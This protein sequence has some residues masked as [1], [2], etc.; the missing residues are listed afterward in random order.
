MSDGTPTPSPPV[1]AGIGARATPQPVLNEITELAQWLAGDGWHLHSGG[2]AGADSTFA[3]ATPSDART[4]FLPWPG[5]RNLSG[6]DCH[7]AT[8]DQAHHTM[9]IAAALHPRWD[10]CSESTKQFHARNVSI[11]LGPNADSPVNAVVCWTEGGRTI[12]GTGMAIRIANAYNIPLINLGQMALDTA[13]QVLDKVREEH[14]T[15]EQ[16]ANQSASELLS[17]SRF[18]PKG[19]R[20]TIAPGIP[21]T[22]G[23]RRELTASDHQFSLD[24]LRTESSYRIHPLAIQHPRA[25]PPQYIEG[26]HSPHDGH[27]FVITGSETSPDRD[28]V[29]H[30]LDHRFPP[31]EPDSYLSELVFVHTGETPAER[32]AGE[33]AL[34]RN[35]P[36]II[37]SPHPAGEN[38]A[39][40]S[41][42]LHT[43]L[44][45]VGL[46][47]ICDFSP[48]EEHSDVTMIARAHRRIV[49]QPGNSLTHQLFPERSL[50][51]SDRSPQ[52]SDEY[53]EQDSDLSQQ[54]AH[55]ARTAYDPD[56]D[57]NAWRDLDEER[58]LE[59]EPGRGPDSSRDSEQHGAGDGLSEELGLYGDAVIGDED[60]HLSADIIDAMHGGPTPGSLTSTG[61]ITDDLALHGA[62][63]LRSEQDT[64]DV[65]VNLGEPL[66]PDNELAAHIQ[67]A[68]DQIID[69]ILTYLDAV[70]PPGFQ[71]EDH[72]EGLLWNEINGLHHQHTQ[73]DQKIKQ[74]TVE[75]ETLRKT[76][77]QRIQELGR[78]GASL[79]LEK[80]TD[81]LLS[82]SEKRDVFQLVRDHMAELYFRE[83]HKVWSPR[84]GSHVSRSENIASN[85]DSK[86]FHKAR[87]NVVSLPEIPEGTLIAVTGTRIGTGHEKIIDTL[88]RYKQQHPDM[89]LLHG[90]SQGTQR[91]CSKW[92]GMRGVPEVALPPDFNKY[93][94]Q[95]TAIKKRDAQI[96]AA[97]PDYVLSFTGPGEKL[98]F[99]HRQAIER[100]ISTEHV[101]EKAV[102]Q[103]SAEQRQ[104]RETN[105]ARIEAQQRPIDPDK[106]NVEYS[107]A[108]LQPGTPLAEQAP[109]YTARALTAAREETTEAFETFIDTALPPETA[110]PEAAL[111][112]EDQD[113]HPL[114]TRLMTRIIDAVHSVISGPDG[115]DEQLVKHATQASELNRADTQNEIDISQ[116]QQNRDHLDYTAA[117][118]DRLEHFRHTIAETYHD[119]TG[120]RWAP[121]LPP[122]RSRSRPVTAAST[123]AVNHIE[124]LEQE[125]YQ[126]RLPAGRPIAVTALNTDADRETVFAILDKALAKHPG[127]WLAHGNAP[128]VLRD[129]SE[130]AKNNKVEQVH[131]LPDWKK[132]PQG[133]IKHRDLEILALDPIG[134]IE[135]ND[136]HKPSKL[137]EHLRERNPNRVLTI[138]SSQSKTDQQQRDRSQGRTATQQQSQDQAQEISAGISW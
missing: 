65:W 112:F 62:R 31:D 18:I 61:K 57:S 43:L 82:A 37:Y 110:L 138:P 103:E 30:Y 10:H 52:L 63:P 19:P 21:A 128:G 58:G 4:Q 67:A 69:G 64:R 51:M 45:R 105:Q 91:T 47:T 111:P 134:V 46:R 76:Q 89:V 72:R 6:P 48:A 29:F 113:Q 117:A 95:L 80:K 127:A 99:M 11:I 22:P 96:L 75:I 126:S 108:L 115:A 114:R 135:F 137:A 71:M 35:I 73:Q 81:E 9:A 27:C 42:R 122:D 12:G 17:A 7:I 104:S 26:G 1:Y 38:P 13:R 125:R 132:H 88:D 74:I 53:P 136:G 14:L 85:I 60:H 118:L 90:N 33:W 28:A 109:P 133:A 66:S 97:K 102:T 5:F 94:D 32:I 98:P 92:A 101:A 124:R 20:P 56:H 36:Q 119:Q 120:E 59:R 130:W 100:G 131:F 68:F 77:P 106:R 44:D 49:T 8:P 123:A 121:E 16:T 87:N 50:T 129:V 83:N 23:E 34:D 15:A 39:Q 3:T 70:A 25:L 24:Q 55:D 78:D 93:N 40:R 86:E 84:K 54:P 79:E 41:A 116:Q 2:A 107:K